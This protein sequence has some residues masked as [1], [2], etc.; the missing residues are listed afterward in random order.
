MTA[1]TQKKLRNV[2]NY[3]M[4]MGPAVLL[5]VVIGLIPFFY[6]IG[7][8]FTNW[9]GIHADYDIVGLKNY[10]DVFT[11]DT[12]YWHAMWFTIK[13]AVCVLIFSNL[14]G[15]VW[16]YGLSKKIP[17]RNVMRAGFY[18]PRIVGGVILGFLW[19]FIITELFPVIGDVTGIGWFSQKWFQTEQSSF[20]AMVIVMTW[21]MAGY[22]MIIYVAGLTSISNDYI[23]AATIDGASSA[24]VL[25]HIILPLLMPSI[26]QCLFLSVVN[27]LKVYD[28]NISLT[29]GNPFRLSEA[30]TMNVYQTAFSSNQMGYGSAKALILVLVIA[31]IS[32]VQVA[33]T[34]SKEVE[35]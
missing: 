18:I 19:R 20:W 17:F 24:C 11:N 14:L 15:F 1:K 34:S 9:D 6:E 13:F 28:L 35:L 29:N 31:G 30:V 3:V 2:M 25:R 8:S 32:L 26:T 27:S 23:E 5:F 21:S 4:F 12:K 33:I 16:A 22:M 7:Y 10:I